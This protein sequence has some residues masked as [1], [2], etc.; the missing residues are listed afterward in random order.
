MVDVLELLELMSKNV[1]RMQAAG[2]IASVEARMRDLATLLGDVEK[3]V[4]TFG[5]QGWL[6]HA[7][8]MRKH[9][10]HLGKLDA[11]ITT[12]LGTLMKFY[13]VRVPEP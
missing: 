9:S 2:G 4:V 6:R 8:K 7:L 10:K 1:S 13:Q 3:V 12:Q 5:Q 11:E